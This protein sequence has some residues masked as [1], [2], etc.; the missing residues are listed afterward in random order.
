MANIEGCG[1][2]EVVWGDLGGEDSAAEDSGFEDG[3]EDSDK[4]EQ[5]YDK[6]FAASDSLQNNEPGN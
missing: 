6:L 3:E 2:V 1:E 5:L 4:E